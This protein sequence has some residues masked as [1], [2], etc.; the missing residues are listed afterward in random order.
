MSFWVVSRRDGFQFGEEAFYE[1]GLRVD[2]APDFLIDFSGGFFRVL[3]SIAEAVVFSK[4]WP[5]IIFLISG[6]YHGV[7]P[8]VS[9]LHLVM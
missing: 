6:S 1:G 3:R 4:S 5:S 8:S 9:T 2:E 7:L